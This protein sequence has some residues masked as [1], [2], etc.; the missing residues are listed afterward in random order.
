MNNQSKTK[1]NSAIDTI[2]PL[3]DVASGKNVSGGDT[4]HPLTKSRKRVDKVKKAKGL[5]M[6]FS[7][8]LQYFSGD[9]TNNK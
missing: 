8:W 1:K 3:T 5:R 2:H 6:E 4:I 7:E 9:N